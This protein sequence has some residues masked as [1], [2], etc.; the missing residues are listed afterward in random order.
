MKQMKHIRNIN[1][2][3]TLNFASTLTIAIALALSLMS[4]SNEN[5]PMSKT[6]DAKKTPMTFK[7]TYP[8]LS[9]RATEDGF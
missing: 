3:S 4:C 9:T 5:E 6:L 1:I 7:A 2:G 8:G